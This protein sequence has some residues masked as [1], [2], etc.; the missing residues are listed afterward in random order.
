MAGVYV[1]NL[2]NSMCLNLVKNIHHMR[3]G[4]RN[5]LCNGVV[6]STPAKVTQYAEGGQNLLTNQGGELGAMLAQG[7][8]ADKG[9]ENGTEAGLLMPP[10]ELER[11]K[12][13]K[14]LVTDFSSCISSVSSG[15]ETQ[16]DRGEQVTRRKKKK[17]K[18]STSPILDKVTSKGPK[19]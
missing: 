11:R 10:P 15:E 19:N 17:R 5:L 6:P 18:A 1:N 7:Q 9:P 8:E 3:F 12:S 13:V 2:E 14:D 16:G 4:D